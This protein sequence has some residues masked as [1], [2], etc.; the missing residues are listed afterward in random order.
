ML[1]KVLN[2]IGVAVVAAALS[3]LAGMIFFAANIFLT[4]PL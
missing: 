4:A 3:I 1:S 2:A